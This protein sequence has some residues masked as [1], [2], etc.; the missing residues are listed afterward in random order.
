[1]LIVISYPYV[2]SREGIRHDSGELFIRSLIF[3]F[4]LVFTQVQGVSIGIQ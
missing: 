2:S 1:M 3:I 4:I